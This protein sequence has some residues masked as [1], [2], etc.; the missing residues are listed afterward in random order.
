MEK[1]K[2]QIKIEAFDVLQKVIDYALILAV[3]I[4]EKA[5]LII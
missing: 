1:R 2:I 5:A 4:L 3:V